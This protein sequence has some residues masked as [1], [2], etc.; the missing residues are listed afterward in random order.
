MYFLYRQKCMAVSKSYSRERKYHYRLLEEITR[1]KLWME[2]ILNKFSKNSNSFFFQNTLLI[3]LHL[4][5]IKRFP[6]MSHVDTK[7]QKLLIPFLLS[8]QFQSI[9]KFAPFISLDEKIYKNKIIPWWGWLS[10]RAQWWFY[11]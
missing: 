10:F 2:V 8:E 9:T 3:L 5:L 1:W 11:F 6:N 4:V 7:I